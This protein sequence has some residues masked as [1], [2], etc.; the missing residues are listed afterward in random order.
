MNL[1]CRLRSRCS[2]PNI[3]C[4]RW[5]GCWLVTG[6]A[7]IRHSSQ[8]RA[9]CPTQRH[10]RNGRA[11]RCVHPASARRQLRTV[12]TMVETPRVGAILRYPHRSKA[13]RRET[14][15]PS[16]PPA[17]TE[18]GPN[19]CQLRR[20]PMRAGCKRF[21]LRP[22]GRSFQAATQRRALRSESGISRVLPQSGKG[23][24]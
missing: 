4:T 6:S 7:T 2:R 22:N 23:G 19:G 16:M 3:S 21:R 1:N 10:E 24:V 14:R 5:E 9:T 18:A 13:R 17:N 12:S 15:T 8:P 20:V 11:M